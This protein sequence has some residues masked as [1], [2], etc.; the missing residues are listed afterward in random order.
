[1]RLL[2]AALLALSACS[3][4]ALDVYNEPETIWT[5]AQMGGAAFP[6]G[7][8]LTFPEPTEIAGQGPCNR[9][10]GAMNAAYPQFA[11]GPIGSTRMA[12]PDMA[13]ETA[14]LAGLETATTAEASENTLTL[15]NSDGL[16]M[17]FKSTD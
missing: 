10:F 17:V 1:V 5:L 2:C 9:Y 12:C 11:A 6:A 4:D 8:T 14:F 16:L 3:T 7:A 13:A 15:S